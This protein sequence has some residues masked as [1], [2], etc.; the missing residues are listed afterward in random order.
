[1][2]F[3]TGQNHANLPQM[4]DNHCT[5]CHAP[6]DGTEFGLSIKGAHTVATRSA[7][8]PG[9]VFSIVRVDNAKPNQKPIVTFTVKDYAGNAVDITK[10]TN[11]NLVMA[12]PTADYNGYVSESAKSASLSPGGLYAYTFKAAL[13]AAASGSYAVAIEGYSTVTLNP[14]TVK[15]AAVRDVGANQVFYFP[16]GDAAK[17]TPRRTVVTQER[18]TACHERFMMHGG[19]RQTVE[20]CVICHN[21][22]VTDSGVRLAANK[23]DESINFKTMI[24]KIH[25]GSNLTRDFTIIG[26]GA[27]VNNYNEVGYVG[28]RRDCERCHVPGSYDLPLNDGLISQTAP[29]DY[30]NPMPPATGAC[31]SCHTTKAAAAH[32]SVMTSPT[33]GESCEACHG[34]N[35]DASVVKVHAR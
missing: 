1:V 20:Y 10:M 29:R 17:A 26:H 6:S 24:H 9:V 35:A 15:A 34:P 4:S 30:L 23:P 19:S 13:P 2:N 14:N 21:P 7:Q 25:T 5:D 8:R 31:L 11:L 32:A 22:T 16:V 12:G 33:L 3:A 18:C 27:S 28:D